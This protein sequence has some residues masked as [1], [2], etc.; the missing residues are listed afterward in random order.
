M[1]IFNVRFPAVGVARQPGIIRGYFRTAGASVV[2]DV[3]PPP[4]VSAAQAVAYANGQRVAS[5]VVDGLVQFTL[6]TR[7]G[8]PADWAVT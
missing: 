5:T 1:T 6:P 7:S 8:V 2:L 4:G 3:A